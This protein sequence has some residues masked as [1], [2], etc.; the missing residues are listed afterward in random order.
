MKLNKFISDHFPDVIYPSRIDVK[1]LHELGYFKNP[2]NSDFNT[3]LSWPPNIFIILYSLLEYTDKYRLIV[4]PQEH[5]KWT[6]TE[7]KTVNEVAEEWRNL[8]NFTHK[9]VMLPSQSA[10]A[11]STSILEKYLHVVFNL[12]NYKTCVYELLDKDDFIKAVF[13]LI[14]SI[15]ELFS[16]INICDL[17]FSNNLRL[18]LEIRNLLRGRTDNLADNK[19]M[20]GFVTFK[21]NVPQSGLTIN[22]LTQNITCIKP[23][24]KPKI[25]VNKL[26]KKSFN[27]KAYNILVLPWPMKIEANWF[28]EVNVEKSLEMDDYFGFF[29]YRP[30]NGEELKLSHFLSAIYSAIQRVGS[31]DL[32]VFPECALNDKVFKDFTDSLFKA[33]GEGA[34]S[35]LAGV[36][37][38]DDEFGKNAAKLA[39]IGESKTFDSFE[40]K[41]HHRWYLDESQLRNYNL[42]NSLD[43][44]K[45]WWEHIQ[46]GRRHLMTLHTH[47]GVKLCPLICEDLARQE[48]VA[49]AVRAVGP[50]LVVS[51]LLDGPQ[52]SQRWPGKYA[53]V[54]SDDP[55]SSVLSVTNLGMTLR[56]TGLGNSPSRGVAL[57]SEPGKGSETLYLDNDGVGIV[58]G[59]E[60]QD[61]LLWSM[62]GRSKRKPI[63]RKKFHSTI[64][65]NH[66]NAKSV[67]LRKLLMEEVKVGEI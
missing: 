24:V 16:D 63:L 36:Y 58:I 57:W 31:L 61:E 38:E 51:L 50:N 32:I 64:Y 30:T 18:C 49:Q 39:F 22:N 15:D 45:K 37:G 43:P 11:T 35:L 67:F 6:A 47:D 41:K 33:F 48:P 5:F 42:S 10:V 1:I 52:L 53:A 56:S 12:K 59:L 14:L 4:S 25:I 21:T 29:E 3:I 8:I 62:D 60:M 19:N 28:K 46:I 40:Q 9:K 20:H 55:G 23:A 54:L 44:G 7:N 34:P 17:K 13:V 2:N 65:D 27:K 66:P 26:V